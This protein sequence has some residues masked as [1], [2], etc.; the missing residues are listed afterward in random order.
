MDGSLFT[1]GMDI[2]DYYIIIVSVIMIF[3]ISLLQ[4]KGINLRQSLQKKN[5]AVQFTAV[6]ALI[7]FI[8]IFGAYGQGYI[9]VDPI[10]A[11]F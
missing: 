3:V 10:Y 7:M 9:P 8:V 11:G 6:Y 5:L 1:L 2:F 4:E